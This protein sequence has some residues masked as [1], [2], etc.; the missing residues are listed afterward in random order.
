MKATLTF[1][2]TFFIF[3]SYSQNIQVEIDKL[4]A[5]V[6]NESFIEALGFADKLIGD[7]IKEGHQDQ[8]SRVYLLRGIAKYELELETDAI[9]DLKIAQSFDNTNYIT[10]LYISDIYYK[11]SNFPSALQNI[12]YFLEKES[13][14]VDALVLKSK[15]ELE[16]GNSNGAKMT[17]Q[18]AL[19]LKSSD[20]HLYYIRAVVNAQLGEDNL[21]CK[22]I[23]IAVR[24]GLEDPEGKIDRFCSKK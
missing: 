4:Q 10:Y 2:L 16:M 13:D 6:D 19:A 7:K 1:F 9:V 17:I 21:A 14:N 5:L 15:C 3:I 24:F 23:K 22:D 12:I 18:K 11:M 20:P 8:S